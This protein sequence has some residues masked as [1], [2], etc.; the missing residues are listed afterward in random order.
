MT[1]TIGAPWKAAP[2]KPFSDCPEI[3]PASPVWQTTRLPAP[4]RA[5][6]PSASPAPTGIITPRRP[7]LELRAAG[8]PRD[9]AGDVEAAAEAVDDV[10]LVEEPERRQRG[11]VADARVPVLDGVVDALVVGERQRHEQRR[12]QL[13]AAAEMI[14]VAGLGERDQ[15]LDRRARRLLLQRGQAQPVLRR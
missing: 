15:R 6:R 13:E 14:D 8:H 11:V 10:R 12:N 1:N 5:L 9:V 4:F 2:L 7:E 3:Q